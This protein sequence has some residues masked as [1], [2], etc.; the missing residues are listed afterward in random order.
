VPGCAGKLLRWI[1]DG[2]PSRVRDLLAYLLF[3]GSFTAMWVELGRIDARARHDEL[4]ALLTAPR[5]DR[6]LDPTAT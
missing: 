4:C 6:T 3:D 5:G 1:A 2:E